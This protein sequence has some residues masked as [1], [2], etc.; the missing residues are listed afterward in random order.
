[1]KYAI[2][3]KNIVVSICDY[4][5]CKDDLATRNEFSIKVDENVNVDDIYENGEFSKPQMTLPTE[6]EILI[7]IRNQRNMLLAESD[8]T[9]FPDVQLTFTK[10]KKQEWIN[11]RKALRNFPEKCED[12]FNP[13]F[14]VKPN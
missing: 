5:P 1:M 14:P 2:I 7:N 13:I 9:Q 8:Y 11:Y 10:A 12:I 3:K 6:E 4:E